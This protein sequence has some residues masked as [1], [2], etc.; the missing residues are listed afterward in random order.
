MHWNRVSFTAT[1]EMDIGKTKS[2]KFHLSICAHFDV[3]E[4]EMEQE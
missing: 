1:K 3:Q 4:E 2:D